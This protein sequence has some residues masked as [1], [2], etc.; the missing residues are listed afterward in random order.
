[1]FIFAQFRE[2]NSC[3]T[4]SR[5]LSCCQSSNFRKTNQLGSVQNPESEETLWE[6]EILGAGGKPSTFLA[7]RG[8]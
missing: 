4:A 3:K 1:M 8:L 2:V 7:A 6:R 5:E